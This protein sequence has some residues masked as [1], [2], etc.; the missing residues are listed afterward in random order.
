MECFRYLG[1]PGAVVWWVAPY[2]DVA[3]IGWRRFLNLIPEMV[4]K[5]VHIKDRRIDMVNDAS[6][7]FKSGDNQN[8]LV[9]EGLD[10]LVLDE[11]ARLREKTFY[12]TLRP[13]L[14]DPD[15]LGHC[16][17]ISTPKS[18]NWFHGIFMRGQDD[19]KVWQSWRRPYKD[20]M[21]GFPTWGNPYIRPRD[22]VQAKTLPE[23]V[24]YQEYAS[25]FL[26]DLGE[27][28]RNILGAVKGDLLKGPLEG[29]E[30]VAG[31]DWGRASSYTVVSVLDVST[32]QLVAYDRFR[33]SSWKLQVKRVAK[34]LRDYRAF[35]LADA[36]GLGDPVHEMLEAEYDNVRPFKITAPTKADIIENLALMIDKKEITYPDI[37][38]LTNELSM[39]GMQQRSN[40]VSY[41]APRGQTDDFVISLAL[42]AWQL[43]KAV[44]DIGFEFMPIF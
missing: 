21:A 8:A 26:S 14:D 10:F 22:L 4:I 5:K 37:P 40:S 15:H 19:G 7:W 27:V 3:M 23:R 42:A 9:G 11:A 6:I 16:M 13:N 18:F 35:G 24:Y 32:G 1:K 38:E 17:A 43:R 33:K 30:Y 34:L 39:F 31:I 2:Q 29:A 20:M 25:C 36:S 44:R 41:K 28:F 12:E